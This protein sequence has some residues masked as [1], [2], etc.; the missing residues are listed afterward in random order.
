MDHR[1]GADS[2]SSI[3]ADDRLL[4]ADLT[5]L[6]KTGLVDTIDVLEGEVVSRSF[7]MIEITVDHRMCI[8]I[9]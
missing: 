8:M 9:C 3:L 4:P 6:R 5:I 7:N 2:A 1:N